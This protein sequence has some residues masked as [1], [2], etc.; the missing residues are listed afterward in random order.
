MYVYIYVYVYLYV[1]IL[2]IY[3][4]T[5]YVWIVYVL[6]VYMCIWASRKEFINRRSGEAVQKKNR[7]HPPFLSLFVAFCWQEFINRHLGEAVYKKIIDPFVSGVYAGDPSELRYLNTFYVH[8]C[9]CVYMYIYHLCIIHK[10]YMYDIFICISAYTLMYTYIY[11]CIHVT[12]RTYV[13][14]FTTDI[15]MH[16]FTC[17]FPNKLLLSGMPSSVILMYK[18]TLVRTTPCDST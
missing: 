13:Q 2:C 15:H 16:V 4:Y 14:I 7:W 9:V 8:V 6:Y 1:C 17:I 10:Y 12:Y 5:V 3:K 18:Y 11:T